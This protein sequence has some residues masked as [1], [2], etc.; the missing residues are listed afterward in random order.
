MRRTALRTAAPAAR[1]FL[2]IRVPRA[3]SP[4]RPQL[5]PVFLE[6]VKSFRLTVP[7]SKCGFRLS[8]PHFLCF[9]R[10]AGITWLLADC[11]FPVANLCFLPVDSFLLPLLPACICALQLARDVCGERLLSRAGCSPSHALYLL[12]DAATANSGPH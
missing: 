1:V 9:L 2:M 8:L 12:S 5:E 11:C 7:G 4:P 6:S 3:P 10:S